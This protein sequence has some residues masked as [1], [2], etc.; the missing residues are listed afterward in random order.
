MSSFRHIPFALTS[1]VYVNLLCQV[2]LLNFKTS[3]RESNIIQ[4]HPE[5]PSSRP[6]LYVNVI[7]HCHK[8]INLSWRHRSE[9]WS[10]IIQTHPETPSPWQGLSMLSPVT[11]SVSLTWR[12]R[13][14]KVSPFLKTSRDPFVQTRSANV[15]SGVT[16]SYFNVQTS[17]RELKYHYSDTSRGPFA[18]V[19]SVIVSMVSHVTSSV[20]SFWRHRSQKVSS[21]RLNQRPLRPDKVHVMSMLSPVTSSDT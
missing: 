18:H 15:P 17:F 21:L 7:I 9:N 11:Y 3:F 20:N 4:T 19:W 12:H 16:F 5:I 13:S 1:S 6:G 14:E 8:F 10:I 2:Q